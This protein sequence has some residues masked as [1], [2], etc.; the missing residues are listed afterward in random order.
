MFYIT[1]NLKS[2]CS[3]TFWCVPALK[4]YCDGH[5]SDLVLTVGGTGFS[6][7][8]VTPEAT[9]AMVER[10]TPGLITRLCVPPQ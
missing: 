3:N 6:P 7:R 9:R 2:R 5:S 4:H 8:D 10:F 1:A